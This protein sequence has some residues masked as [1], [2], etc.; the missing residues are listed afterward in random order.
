MGRNTPIRARRR[1]VQR[2]AAAMV[3]ILLWS[4][5]EGGTPDEGSGQGAASYRSGGRGKRCEEVRLSEQRG[6]V[7]VVLVSQGRLEARQFGCR[8]FARP[9]FGNGFSV[10]VGEFGRLCGCLASGQG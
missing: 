6:G 2:S 8:N 10:V 1:R 3:E 4:R 9:N 5:K 7:N